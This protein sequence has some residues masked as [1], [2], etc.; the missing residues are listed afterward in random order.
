MPLPFL[1]IADVLFFLIGSSNIPHQ[2]QP[3][4]PEELAIY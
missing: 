4:I 3:G 1:K 2:L